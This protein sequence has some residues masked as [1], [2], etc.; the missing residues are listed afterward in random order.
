MEA[1]KME[2]AMPAPCHGRVV[3]IHCAVGDAVEDGRLLI[4]LEADET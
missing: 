2:H 4:T 3:A 1:M